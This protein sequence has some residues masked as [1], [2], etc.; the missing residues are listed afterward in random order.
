MSKRYL[1]KTKLIS[2]WQCAKRLWLEINDPEA[3]V[4]TLE[5]RR[6]FAIGH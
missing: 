5:T 6:A 4:V 3:K 2:G 1:S